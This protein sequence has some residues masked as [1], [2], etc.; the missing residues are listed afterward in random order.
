MPA[1]ST[2]QGKIAFT[3]S[4]I[5]AQWKTMGTELMRQEPVFQKII[6]ECDQQLRRYADS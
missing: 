5:G 3:F 1:I 6:R 2:S 4:G